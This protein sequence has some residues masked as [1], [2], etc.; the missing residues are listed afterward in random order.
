M[1]RD[2]PVKSSKPM[3]ALRLKDGADRLWLYNTDDDH[4]GHA[5]VESAD[6]LD[7]VQ[8]VS[9]YPIQPVRFL[10]ESNTSFAYNYAAQ[11]K[12]NKFQTKLAP[13]GVTIVDIRR[14]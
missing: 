3:L 10:Q 9:A 14:A 13:G 8:V 11:T 12:Q 6:P 4:Y 7:D 1:Q 2:F 5:V